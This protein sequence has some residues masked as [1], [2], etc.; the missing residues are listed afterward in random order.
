MN[1]KIC[2]IRRKKDLSSCERA[3]ADL[4]GF[5]NI[6]RSK[7]MIEIPEITNLTSSMKD[8]NKAVLVIE[9]ENMADAIERIEKTGLKNIQLHSLSAD[10]INNL[11]KHYQPTRETDKDRNSVDN[12]G[13]LRVIRALGLSTEIGTQKVREIQDFARVCDCLLFDYQIRG[14][15]GGT[16]KQIPLKLAVEAAEIA[17]HTKP[18]LKIFLAGGMDKKRMEEK[19][20]ILEEFFDYVDVNSKVE[21]E[22]GVKNTAKIKELI[23]IKTFN[24]A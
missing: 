18:D 22:P 14:K 1:I 9:P 5:I 4:I 8:K 3:G 24:K 11:K 7:R 17:K 23:E 20:E 19:F 13:D 2:G 16:G 12:Q 15:T 21:D 6:K 10:E